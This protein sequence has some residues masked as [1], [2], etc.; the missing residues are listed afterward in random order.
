MYIRKIQKTTEHMKPILCHIKCFNNMGQK[1]T[2]LKN[3]AHN[4]EFTFWVHKI[5]LQFAIWD[6]VLVISK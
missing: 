2:I 5:S 1:Y 4:Q 6:C 3:N